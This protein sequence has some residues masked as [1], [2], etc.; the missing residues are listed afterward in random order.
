MYNVRLPVLSGGKLRAAAQYRSRSTQ[1]ATHA[2]RVG[3]IGDFGRRGT[4][5]V[6]MVFCTQPG[7]VQARLSLGPSAV[8]SSCHT[9]LYTP[10]SN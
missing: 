8:Q 3:V 6:V 1:V 9:T 5:P 10:L 7:R 4:L 2:T